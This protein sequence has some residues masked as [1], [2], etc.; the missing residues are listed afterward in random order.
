MYVP[1]DFEERRKNDQAAEADQEKEE[2]GL[3]CLQ[4]KGWCNVRIEP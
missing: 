1:E 4:T 3:S 2:A